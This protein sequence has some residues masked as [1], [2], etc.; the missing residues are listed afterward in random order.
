MPMRHN[1]HN[2]ICFKYWNDSRRHCP[3]HC[4]AFGFVLFF[5]GRYYYNCYPTTESNGPPVMKGRPPWISIA[6][7]SC[8]CFGS[9]YFALMDLMYRNG[10]LLPR[11]PIDGVKSRDRR[12]QSITSP[13]PPTVSGGWKMSGKNHRINKIYIPNKRIDGTIVDIDQTGTSAAFSTINLLWRPTADHH[14]QRMQYNSVNNN[15]NCSKH[16]SFNILK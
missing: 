5:Y 10:P 16:L 12:C 13:P 2:T 15:N 8:I 7:K 1:I 11:A 6:H 4:R 9:Y 3:R 14:Q